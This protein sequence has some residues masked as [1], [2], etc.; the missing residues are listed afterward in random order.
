[1]LWASDLS[2]TDKSTVEE[3]NIESCTGGHYK[4]SFQNL[5]A[6]NSFPVQ[7]RRIQKEAK[8]SPQNSS[9]KEELE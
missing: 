6:N 7:D 8:K 9:K 2:V 4:Y 5:E 3:M 1:M